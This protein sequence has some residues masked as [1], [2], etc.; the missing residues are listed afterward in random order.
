MGID[1]VFNSDK[2]TILKNVVD[3]NGDDVELIVDYDKLETWE[4]HRRKYAKKDESTGQYYYDVKFYSQYLIFRMGEKIGIDVPKTE[5][6]HVD[7]GFYTQA[8]IVY[9]ESMKYLAHPVRSSQGKSFLSQGRIWEEYLDNNYSRKKKEER[10]IRPCYGEIQRMQIDDYINANI[11]CLKNNGSKPREKYTEN[12]IG[13][14]K[15][16]LITRALFGLRFGMH[17]HFHVVA[18]KEKEIDARLGSYFLASYD[19]FY[20]GNPEPSIKEL[21]QENDDVLKRKVEERERPQYYAVPGQEIE[22]LTSRDVITYIYEHYPQ[23]AERAYERLRQFTQKDFEEILGA[24]SEMSDSHKKLAL[25]IF[26]IRTQEYDQIHQ[27]HIKTQPGIPTAPYGE[28][29]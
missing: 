11:E 16:E 3:Y 23:E 26:G 21:L 17:G 12:E 24:C 28:G 25:R 15:Q 27:Q 7:G 6:I 4:V 14:W 5:V 29:R 8:S 19:A 10:V 2:Y 9:D 18:T 13:E 22:S 1:N 20:L